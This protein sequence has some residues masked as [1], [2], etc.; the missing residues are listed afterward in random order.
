MLLLYLQDADL[1]MKHLKMLVLADCAVRWWTRGLYLVL[2][3]VTTG[4]LT[5]GINCLSVSCSQ[6]PAWPTELWAALTQSWLPGKR[7][8]DVVLGVMGLQL[9]CRDTTDSVL[10]CSEILLFPL[11]WEISSVCFQW[12]RAAGTWA[13]WGDRERS[14]SLRLLPLCSSLLRVA[15][16]LRG[17]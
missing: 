2:N 8:A 12:P 17:H 3:C 5:L 4:P 9:P 7:V 16:S 1:N 11:S 13:L 10:S 15:H 14:G 6:T